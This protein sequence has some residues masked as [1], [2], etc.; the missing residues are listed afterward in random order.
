MSRFLLIGDTH[1]EMIAIANELAFRNL[2]FKLILPTYFTV[3]EARIIANLGIRFT[4]FDPWL[5]KRTLNAA[6]TKKQL[7][8]KYAVLEL[9]TWLAKRYG[10]EQ[11]F[12]LLWQSYRNLLSKNMSV[13]LES[14]CPETV[15]S[16]DTIQLPLP[17]SYRHIVIC[18]MTHPSE[19]RKALIHSKTL[20]PNWPEMND[21]TPMGISNTAREADTLVVLSNFAKQSYVSQ[22]ME[23]GKIEVIHIGPINGSDY[24]QTRSNAFPSSKLSV[25]YLG[26]M[27]RIKGID[28]L[29]Q[30]SHLLDPSQISISLVGQSSPEITKYIRNKCNPD[31]LSLYVNPSP[32]EVTTFYRNSHIFVLPSFNEGFGIASLEA[33]TY[34]LI[35]I[36]ST[37]TGVSEILDDTKLSNLVI[38]PGDVS[39]LH[40]NLNF[41]QSLN[42]V[43]FTEYQQLAIDIS[44][45]F[46]F[47]NFSKDFVSRILKNG[48]N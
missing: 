36:L 20:F 37:S 26:R 47:S 16:Y 34:G 40:T 48:D 18:P 30:V 6:I 33:M 14:I 12:W 19:V 1:P 2:S 25:L 39:Q 24:P 42:L 3:G 13:I 44:K 41:L 35:P 21:E 38:R 46:S 5:K 7:I 27:T 32:S 17:S 8:R 22:G 28:A 11:I 23:P 10:R 45:K 9:L 29:I 43:Q 15:I 31:V 4:K